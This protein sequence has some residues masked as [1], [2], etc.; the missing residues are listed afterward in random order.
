MVH[1]PQLSPTPAPSFVFISLGTLKATNVWV[2]PLTLKVWPAWGL[3]RASWVRLTC[4]PV[5]GLGG[6]GR[7]P[8]LSGW[9]PLDGISDPRIRVFSLCCPSQRPV[10]QGESPI[11]YAPEREVRCGPFLLPPFSPHT[12]PRPPAGQSQSPLLKPGLLQAL[13]SM[14]WPPCWL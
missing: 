11:N 7:H 4:P 10:I 6:Q 14:C 5:G 3:L 13:P 12:H 1:L 8:S 2:P 9:F